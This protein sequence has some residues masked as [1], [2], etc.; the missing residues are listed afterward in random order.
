MAYSR[1]YMAMAVGAVRTLMGAENMHLTDA[2]AQVSRQLGIPRDTLDEWMRAGPTYTAR[3]DVRGAARR[4]T[5]NSVPAEGASNGHE[6]TL[7]DAE[8]RLHSP[9]R[10]PRVRIAHGVGDRGTKITGARPRIH[11]H[12]TGTRDPEAPQ[13]SEKKG[14]EEN[15]GGTQHGSPEEH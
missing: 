10:N 2:I 3:E 1:Q 7:R 8:H 14:P 5:A 15:G 13:E 9:R 4:A 6:Y 11:G 12:I